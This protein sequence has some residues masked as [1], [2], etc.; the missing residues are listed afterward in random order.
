[1]FVR[2]PAR[3]AY[4]RIIVPVGLTFVLFVLSVFLIFIPSMEDRMM[5]QK[6][7]MLR[8]LTDSACSLLGQCAAQGSSG[9]LSLEDAQARA[10]GI[11]SKLRYGPEGKDYF[12]I[13]DMHPRM[14]MHPYRPDL[15][16]KD[17]SN[18]ADPKGKHLFLEFV[19][20]VQDNDA[21]YVDYMWQWKDNPDHIVPKISYVKGFKPWGWIIGTGIYVEDVRAE[22]ATITRRMILIFFGILAI[23]LALSLYIIWETVKTERQREEA[24]NGLLKSEKMFRT[25]GEDA[26]FGISMLASN[27]HFEYLNPK[28]T[29]IFGYTKEDL[30]DKET[31]FKKAYPDESYREKVVN[32]WRGDLVENVRVEKIKPRVFTVRCKDGQDKII[33]FRAVALEDGRQLLTY[34]DITEKD[35]MEKT[36][37]EN[38]R[39]YIN[40]YEKSKRAEALYR[41][42]LDSS[43]DAIITYD[44]EGKAQFVSPAFTHIFGWTWEEVE[45]GR[46]P[47]MPESEREKTMAIIHDLVEYGKPCHAFGTKRLTKDGRLLD[48]SISA[49]RYDDH[50]GNP[51]GLLVILRD[52]SGK[53]RLEAQLQHAQRMESIGTLAGGVA[54][55]FNNLLMAIQGN[56]SLILLNKDSDH[57]DYKKIRNIEN[58]V[59]RGASLT[60]Q[61]LGFARSGKYEVTPTSLNE[62]IR[63]STKMFARTKKE[64]TINSKYQENIWTVEADQGQIEQVLL[65]LFVNA[66]QAMSGGGDLFV[67]TENL[68]LSTDDVKSLEIRPGRYVKISVSDTGIG[69]DAD[70][71]ERIFDPFFTTRKVGKGTGLGLASSY[72]IIRNHSGIIDVKSEKGKGS[73]FDI[74]LPAV[75]S[76]VRDQKSEVRESVKP[77]TETIL[78]VDDEEIIIDVSPEMLT[79]LGYEVLT[80]RSGE[81]ALEQYRINRDKIDLVILD[82]IMPDMGGGETYDRLK[83]IDPN[84]MVLLSSGYSIDGQATEILKRGCNGFIQKP[85]N[86]EIL[87][88]KIREILN[89]HQNIS[90]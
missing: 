86:I 40:L 2:K 54:H 24:E 48:V 72:G 59:Q 56:A 49:S 26:P 53:R 10:M 57:P 90:A 51:S 21:G 76:K 61:L 62:I 39:K 27:L 28:F 55:D 75:E 78:L 67:E 63:A 87:S 11:I 18:Y 14:I 4:L 69:M 70:I 64:I 29:E 7:E 88:K 9:K 35:K 52:I 50:E 38:E 81:E 65:N 60:K 31:W 37:K 23:V 33:H 16:G 68:V 15:D 20:T 25:L 3:A 82:M 36:L 5:E 80:A 83:Q 22:I 41:S 13:N 19:K 17:L 46:I 43:A 85:F 6:R 74:Y 42:L 84:I 34:E 58:Q 73:T 1:M 30:P 71:R 47:F 32:T 12:W 8:G 44:L 77:G 45:G 79:E 66:W 89:N